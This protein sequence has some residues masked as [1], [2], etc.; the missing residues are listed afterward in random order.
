MDAK[1]YKNLMLNIDT[2]KKATAQLEGQLANME[3]IFNETINGLE[4]DE[5]QKVVTL[6][7]MTNRAIAKARKGED[8][9]GVINKI[10]ETFKKDLQNGSSNNG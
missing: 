6:K 9:N 2:A 7:A 4:G 5:K 10:K 3:T 8:Y 1:S